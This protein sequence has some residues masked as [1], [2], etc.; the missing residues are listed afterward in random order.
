MKIWFPIAAPLA[1]PHGIRH[2]LACHLM[3]KNR[4]LKVIA[5]IL[6]HRSIDSTR[7]YAKVDLVGLRHVALLDLGGVL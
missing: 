2:T 6:G 3:S 7:I 5:D 1:T 4:P